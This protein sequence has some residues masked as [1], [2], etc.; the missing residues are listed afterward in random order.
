LYAREGSKL[1]E[2]DRLIDEPTIETLAEVLD[3]FGGWIE[4]VAP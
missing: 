2:A 1:F 3:A 4:L